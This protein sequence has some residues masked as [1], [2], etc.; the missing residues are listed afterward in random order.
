MP[1][2]FV[3]PRALTLHAPG[4]YSPGTS[5]TCASAPS[6]RS[7]RATRPAIHSKRSCVP[8]V[9]RSAGLAQANA[10]VPSWKAAAR[11]PASRTTGSKPLRRAAA[12][13]AAKPGAARSCFENASSRAGRCRRNVAGSSPAATRCR[14]A[15]DT[16]VPNAGRS[17]KPCLMMRRV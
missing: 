12:T 3:R 2:S 16:A 13:A 10:S 5:P 4:Q 15:S 6:C 11:P 1:A 17:A 7:E 8:A 14:I 9:G